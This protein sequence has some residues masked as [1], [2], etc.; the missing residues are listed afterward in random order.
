MFSGFTPNATEQAAEAK[1]TKCGA[2]LPAGA[3]FCLECG[4]KVVLAG[5]ETIVCPQCNQTVAKGKFCPECG[6]KFVTACPA[7]GKEVTP[8]AKFCLECGEK[9]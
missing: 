8:G 9:L 2:T 3:K 5:G 1:C 6:Y 7:C 4:E